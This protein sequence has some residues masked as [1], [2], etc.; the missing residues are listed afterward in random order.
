MKIYHNP[1]C[2]K[3][4]ETLKL[5]ESKGKKVE[6]IDY[7][8]HPPSP[9]TLKTIVEC[10]EIN[11]SD[12]VRRSESL[13]KEKFKNQSF[14]EKE[15]LKILSENPKLIERPIVM[16]GKKAII[17]RPPEKVLELL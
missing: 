14:T 6:I 4:R 13:F 16:E 9:E 15:W 11:A 3:S 2:T 5:I 12:L 10:L 7:L 1:R 8:N 17:G